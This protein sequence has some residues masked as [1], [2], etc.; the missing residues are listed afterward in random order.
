MSWW[1]VDSMAVTFQGTRITDAEALSPSTP[2][3]GVWEDTAGGAA[4]LEGEFFYE[5]AQSVSEKVKTSET[6]VCFIPNSVTYNVAG[7]TFIFKALATTPGVLQTTRAAGNKIEIGSGATA[8]SGQ[9][10]LY[11]QYYLYT[12]STYPA[13]GGW[14]FPPI[15]LNEAAYVDASPGGAVTLS[16]V[17]YWAHVATMSVSSAKSENLAMDAIDFV[18]TG[19]GLLWV[20][21][22]GSFADFVTFDEGTTGNRYGIATTKDDVIFVGAMLAIGSATATTFT[23]S[24]TKLVFPWA[25]VG[26]GAL[27]IKV[28]LQNASTAVTLD[29]CS[30]TGNGHSVTKKWF[31]TALQT[32][33]T[34]DHITI[35]GHGLNTGDYVTYSREGGSHDI[36]P[37]PGSFWV[38]VNDADTFGLS[39]SRTNAF[40]GTIEALTVPSAPGEN[41]SIIR[42]PDNRADFTVTGTTSTA[43]LVATAC[44][45]EGIRVMTLTSKCTISKGFVQSIG[46]VVAST[47][48]LTTVLLSDFT[49]GEGESLFTPLAAMNGITYCSFDGGGGHDFGHA[50]EITATGSTNSVGN[51]FT[52]YWAPADLG[53][54]FHTQ[55]GVASNVIT[56]NAAHG[57]TSGDAVFYNKEGGTD[58]INLTDAT[59]YYVNVASGT[60]FTVHLTRAAGVA[61]SSAITLADGSGGEIHS[62]YSSK[63][64]VFNDTAGAV[65]INVSGSGDSPSV[66]NGTGASTTVVNTKTLTVTCK[67][68][69]AAVAGLRVRVENTSTGAA[70]MTGT[71]NGSGVVTDATYNYTG[72]LAVTVV[73]R[74]K[75]W[76]NYRAS[77][78]ITTDGLSHAAAMRV[79][80]NVDLP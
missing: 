8:G 34:S 1:W 75:G 31:D 51:K 21:T 14:L 16:A 40:A 79:D 52:N 62:F 53:W 63:A 64:A 44:I 29:V 76:S 66:R 12:K 45:F 26:E 77:D 24:N 23:A 69:A 72:D 74:L 57:F 58:S 18:T 19:Q 70:I 3:A 10:T 4:V 65:T 42:D 13:P 48:A 71:T 11:N 17:N 2:V 56:T 60:T 73:V 6:G 68:G 54:N 78:T 41:Q 46:N 50:M 47:A 28:D 5:G 15:D 49:L 27:G 39:T 35:P 55:T 30:F 43:G 22:G 32:N 38:F 80:E 61:G 37:E 67:L 25:R 20:G 36:G 59:K 9:P 7:D 33:A